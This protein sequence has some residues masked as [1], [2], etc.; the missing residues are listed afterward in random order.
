LLNG[1]H[2][3]VADHTV[4]AARADT[5]AIVTAEFEDKL[6][7]ALVAAWATAWAVA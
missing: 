4:T 3:A 2:T 6:A 7:A 5:F 1:N